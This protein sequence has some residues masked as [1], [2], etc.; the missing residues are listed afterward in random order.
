M[1]IETRNNGERP[2]YL[3]FDYGRTS[4]YIYSSE[5]LDG[6]E[7]HTNKNGKVTFRRYITA[8]S[9]KVSG[10]YFRDNNFGGKDFVLSL[11]DSEGARFNILSDISG[12][13]FTQIARNLP[14]ID[15]E[16]EI[17]IAVY[18]NEYN[19]K[20]YVGVSVSYPG[21]IDENG[22]SVLVKWSEI[23]PPR[24]LKSGKW[25]FTEQQ[26]DTYVKAEEFIKNNGF[27]QQFSKPVVP[28]PPVPVQDE[29]VIEEDDLP[30]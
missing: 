14:N 12:S 10:A 17:R 21:E 30:F 11:T 26:D 5:Q 13:L 4:L 20:T 25:D 1:P 16:K 15:V 23:A 27:D 29:E 8:V 6:Y 28:E 18:P 22:K 2:T 19:G 7:K 24:Q 3:Q 9:G